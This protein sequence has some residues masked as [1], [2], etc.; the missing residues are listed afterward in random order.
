MKTGYLSYRCRHCKSDN[1][2][3]DAIASWDVVRQESILLSEYDSQWCSDCG[4]VRLEEFEITDAVEIALIDLARAA[5]AVEKAAPHLLAAADAALMAL[6]DLAAARAKG[7]VADAITQLMVA[8]AA[9]RPH[10]QTE[11]ARS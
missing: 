3:N 2:G 9:A 8:I 6:S 10:A 1:C 4:D 5:L 11:G 7:Y